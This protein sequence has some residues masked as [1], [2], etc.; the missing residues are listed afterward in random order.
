MRYHPRGEINHAV[1]D[2]IER[3]YTRV[4]RPEPWIDGAKPVAEIAV[5][6]PE[7]GFSYVHPTFGRSQDALKGATRILCE[8]KQQFDVVSAR[9]SWDGYQLLILPDL[10]LLDES[11][12]AKAR[13]HLDRGGAVLATGWS[14]ADPK[15]QTFVL[16]EWGLDLRGG[17]RVKGPSDRFLRRLPLRLWGGLTRG[18]SKLRSR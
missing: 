2:L 14:D 3:V 18:S 13:A 1:F 10:V 9:R 4:Q 15:Q 17:G 7:P 11:A 5:V 8:L 16:K 6:A 12:A